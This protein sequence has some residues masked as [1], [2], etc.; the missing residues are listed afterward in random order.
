MPFWEP[1]V[2]DAINP[3]VSVGTADDIVTAYSQEEIAHRRNPFSRSSL[4]TVTV[5]DCHWATLTTMSETSHLIP[6][7]GTE[8]DSDCSFDHHAPP[9]RALHEKVPLYARP[10]QRQRW[11]D[12]QI[13]YVVRKSLAISVPVF[14]F[15]L[16]R[17]L[18]PL[19]V[20]DHM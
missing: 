7:A 10:R 16:G 12:T 2:C 20:V 4:T 3:Q 15:I 11:N 18:A 14:P 6:A 19:A 13:L 9:Q 8:H 5:T 17:L 1:G